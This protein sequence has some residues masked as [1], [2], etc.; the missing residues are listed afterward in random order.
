MDCS[1]F[2]SSSVSDKFRCCGAMLCRDRSIV[3]RVDNARCVL[4]ISN[5]TRFGG[6]TRELV[7]LG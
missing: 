6:R 5:A 1:S 4:T 3:S 2:S 7:A